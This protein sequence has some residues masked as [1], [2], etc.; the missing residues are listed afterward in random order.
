MPCYVQVVLP[1]AVD[2]VY[3]YDVPAN[4]IDQ[5]AVG[6]RVQ[7]QFGSKRIYAALVVAVIGKEQHDEKRPK[8]I[9][10]IL[11]DDPIINDTTLKLWHWIAD[12][13]LSSLG[14]VMRVALPSA[15]RLSS[16]TRLLLHPSFNED[17]SLL[18]DNEFLIAEALSLQNELSIE[19]AQAILE[20]KNVFPIVKSLLDKG[21]LLVK[22]ELIEKYKP[23]KVAFISLNESYQEEKLLSEI[24]AQLEKRAPKQ[25]AILMA[26]MVLQQK[27]G[28]QKIQK[29][30]VI[31]QAGPDASA[32]HVAALVKKGVF[33]EEKLAISRINTDDESEND[34]IE[35]DLSEHQQ[36]ALQGIKQAFEKKKTVLLHGV[37]SSGKTQ[38]YIEL[39]KAQLAQNRQCLFLMP[40][41]ALTTQMIHRLKQ[42]FGDLIG[43]YHSK[44]NDQ[45]RIE[46]WAKVRNGEYRIVIGARSSMFLPFTDLGLV[47]VDEEHDSSYKQYDPA[48]RYNARDAAIFLAYLHQ[49]NVV[50][51]SATPS[52]ESYYNATTTKKYA[53]VTLTE[54][55]GGVAPPAINLIDLQAAQKEG[56]VQTLFSTHLLNA[57]DRTVEGGE[58]VILFQNRRGYAPFIACQDCGWTAR[59]YQCDVS[60]TYHKYNDQLRCHYCGH[61]AH[62][63]K[64]CGQCGS[65]NL[66]VQGFGTEKIEEELQ[67]IRPELRTARLDL[68][69]ARKK[70]GFERILERLHSGD[71]DVLIGTQMVA[72]GLD[73]DKVRTVGV[74]SADQLL[75]FPDFRAME[76]GFQL[77]LQVSGR[78]GRRS[79][80][81]DVLIQTRSTKYPVLHHV[82]ENDYLSFAQE[83]LQERA[84]YYFPPFCRMVELT[85]KHK[86]KERVN[87][88]AFTFTRDLKQQLKDMVLGP[89]V[90]SVSYVRTY[91]LRTILIKLPKDQ[92]LKAYKTFIKDSILYLKRHKDF[93]SVIVQ[94]NVD[95]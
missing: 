65:T 9:I 51:G 78:S 23:K 84:R 61:H 16:E 40:E 15:F 28:E 70:G 91:H 66:K 34:L 88:A 93:R 5:I 21:V 83:E 11:D 52:L 24:F 85:L 43:V 47:V 53:Y 74:I 69:T 90:P 48:P 95:P 12:Y 39:I 56:Q 32:S 3:T 94:A 63:A 22:E 13:Y 87:Q 76:R 58:Q 71:V 1:L 4:L 73:F 68:E 41:I 46:L 64:S 79:E 59:C 49:A 62:I 57:I 67:L 89:S 2:T 77:L 75:H 30:R 29:K 7:V 18:S 17:Y 27:G 82:L 55:Y 54:R 6:K 35:F 31:Q 10:S 45:E 72:K 25:L 44:F 26:F 92:N 60:M 42:V 80:Q 14:E 86:N 19:E 50:L 33:I 37:T 38:L 20:R 81:G 8:A 36:A